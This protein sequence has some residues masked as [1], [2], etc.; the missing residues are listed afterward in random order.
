[1]AEVGPQQGDDRQLL[2]LPSLETRRFEHMQIVMLA[3]CG[4]QSLSS[5]PSH[6]FPRQTGRNL[7]FEWY[8]GT[9]V[10]WYTGIVSSTCGPLP[11]Q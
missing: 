9:L 10:H 4:M 11:L 1:M 7:G 8:T 2:A 3:A 5:D 6:P